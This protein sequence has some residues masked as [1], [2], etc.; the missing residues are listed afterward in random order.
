MIEPI[1][2]QGDRSRHRQVEPFPDKIVKFEV[3]VRRRR[4]ARWRYLDPLACSEQVRAVDAANRLGETAGR[5]LYDRVRVGI[6]AIPRRGT[7]DGTRSEP[8]DRDSRGP[9]RRRDE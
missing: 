4:V 7:A 8:V 1:G 9:C 6:A 5:G 3:K 2:E